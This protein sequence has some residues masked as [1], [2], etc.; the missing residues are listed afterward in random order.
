MKKSD[1]IFIVCVIL[2]FLPF[3]LLPSVYEW[4]K[5]F[6]QEH[7]MLMSALKFGILATLGEVIG[8]RIQKGVYYEKGFGVLPRAMVWA[9][10]GMVI[11]MAMIVFSKGTPLF[12]LYLGMENAVTVMTETFLSW[13]KVLVA[14]SISVAMNTIF[15]PVF[16]TLH[17]ITDMHILQTGG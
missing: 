7:G 4:Y 15:A 6:N 5:T 13:D 16:M 3:F 9:A 8:L 1:F 12:L 14:F 17:K 11:N 2:F 10:L